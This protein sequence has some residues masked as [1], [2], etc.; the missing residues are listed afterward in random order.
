M[1]A[2]RG[3]GRVLGGRTSVRK[4]TPRKRRQNKLVGE[5]IPVLEKEGMKPKQAIAVAINMGKAGRLRP[6]GVYVPAKKK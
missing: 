4:V 3:A 6:G 5:K 2:T 1:S